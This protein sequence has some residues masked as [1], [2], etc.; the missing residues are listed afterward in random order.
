MNALS[1]SPASATTGGQMAAASEVV[2]MPSE[3][4]M[5]TALGIA[6]NIRFGPLTKDQLVGMVGV[7]GP[8]IQRGLTFLRETLHAPVIFD[9]SA[10]AWELA[11]P[12]WATPAIFVTSTG[13]SVAPRSTAAWYSPRREF[14]VT[15]WRRA[16]CLWHL[17][18]R[19]E[20]GQALCGC[21]FGDDS[22]TH[23]LALDR[24][25]AP[26]YC[27]RCIALKLGRSYGRG[28]P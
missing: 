17:P 10:M 20:P 14:P 27:R 3:E 2:S 26:A 28:T 7:S 16:L 22:P 11:D 18:D 25:Q 9:R 12:S 15:V 1:G 24:A 21:R 5:R 4:V 13:F 6:R 19:D 23:G 8:T